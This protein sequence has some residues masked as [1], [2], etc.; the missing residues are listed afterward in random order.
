MGKRVVKNR[1]LTPASPVARLSGEPFGALLSELGVP[2]R[3]G[4]DT[5]G[6]VLCPYYLVNLRRILYSLSVH[7]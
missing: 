5:L 3:L 7:K 6:G 2:L 4:L 1:N